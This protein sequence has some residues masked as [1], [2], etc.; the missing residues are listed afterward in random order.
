MLCTRRTQSFGVQQQR[1]VQT[2][3][4]DLVRQGMV[5]MNWKEG[6]PLLRRRICATPTWPGA[7]TGVFALGCTSLRCTRTSRYGTMRTPPRPECVRGSDMSSDNV[8]AWGLHYRLCLA[9]ERA[10][11]T[12][13]VPSDG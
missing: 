11:Y 1:H 12:R 10:L 2:K 5:F 9:K 6:E 4:R 3:T 13:E 8:R 7:R